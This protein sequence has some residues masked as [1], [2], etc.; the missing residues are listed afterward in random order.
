MVPDLEGLK[1]IAPRNGHCFL[2]LRVPASPGF[3]VRGSISRRFFR[4]IVDIEVATFLA[5]DVCGLG[6]GLVGRM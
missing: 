1:G 5:L 4:P 6:T 2:L 3:G